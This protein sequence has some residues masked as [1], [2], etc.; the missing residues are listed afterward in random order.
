MKKL[1]VVLGV[2]LAVLLAVFVGAAWYFSSIIIDGATI[3]GD[4]AEFENEV[5]A[6]TPD[7]RDPARGVIAYRVAETMTDP[8][9]DGNTDSIVGMRFED[10]GYLQLAQD[11]EVSGREVTRT[12]EV[13]AGAAPQPGALGKWDWPS[14]PD[15]AA[16][17]LTGEA[18]TYDSPL[19]PMPAQVVQPAAAAT[20]SGT[21]AIV[22]HGRNG[23]IR[24]GLR[25]TRPL[26][27]QGITTMLIN[28]RDD[29]KEPGAPSEDGIGNFGITEWEDLQAA[30]DYATAAG[31]D[32]VLLIGYSM[33][34]AVIG[35]YLQNGA[36]TDEVMGSILVS[37]AVS[38]SRI[39]TFGAEVL[40]YPVQYMGPLIWAAERITELRVDIDYGATDYLAFAPQWPVP[41]LVTAAGRDDLVPPEA[42]EEFTN[43]LPQGQYEFFPGAQHTG[44][45]NFEERRFTGLVRDWLEANVP[46]SAATR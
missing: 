31:A 16:L 42:I 7:P 22:V 5:L 30:V 20:P 32:D 8:A 18:V 38:F 3:K 13:L 28:Y 33:G 17:G 14:F 2:L 9:T 23:S 19:G 10:G 25:I 35:S 6:V 27:D 37:P 26:A 46:A 21:W 36:N 41:T 40:G 44:E 45:W 34:G 43:D 24:E 39:T 15:V 29:L 1:L 12:Y 11:A 4:D